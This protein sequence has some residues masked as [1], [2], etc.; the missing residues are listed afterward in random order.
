MD[1]WAAGLAA[2]GAALGGWLS[3]AG[4]CVCEVRGLDPSEGVLDL[5]RWQ[6]DRCGPE[7]LHGPP[8]EPAAGAG[9]GGF[10]S[11]SAAFAAGLLVGA[12][13]GAAALWWVLRRVSE[14][15][16]APAALPAAP[17]PV[18]S[19]AVATPSQRRRALTDGR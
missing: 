19:P 17:A 8:A 5:L 9:S 7:R 4:R 3:P 1:A 15:A 11:H 6:L 18:A 16:A 13:L 2:A 10:A 14:P 12:V